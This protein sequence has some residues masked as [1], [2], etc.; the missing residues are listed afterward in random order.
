MKM[1]LEIYNQSYERLIEIIDEEAESKLKHIRQRCI[2]DFIDRLES[3]RK[4][5]DSAYNEILRE[6]R[7]AEEIAQI[8]QAQEEQARASLAHLK[9]LESSLV[10]SDPSKTATSDE[11]QA[12]S[13]PVIVDQTQTEK[14]ELVDVAS[15]IKALEKTDSEINQTISETKQSGEKD[16]IF[17]DPA[18]SNS[19]SIKQFIKSQELLEHIRQSISDIST[20][21][22][23]KSYKNE[24]TLFIRTQINS[25]SNS[26]SQHLNTK[27]RLLSSL[28]SGE[29]VSF[30][31]RLIDANQHPQARTYSMDLAAQTF[32]TVGTR[33]VNSVPAI[34]KSMAIVISGIANNN[35]PLFQQLIIGHLQERCPYLIPIHPQ[36]EDYSEGGD[37]Q[38]RFKIA[39]GYNYDTKNSALE[40]EDKYL[41][42]MRSMV[43]IYGCIL[44]QGNLGQ[45]WTWLASYVSLNPQPVIS[46]TVL[47]AFLQE[48]SKQMTSTY[49][50]QFNKLMTF[51]KEHYIKK[52]EEVTSKTSDRQSFIKLT[53][54]LSNMW[55]C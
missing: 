48:T 37:R 24:L 23:H 30:Q 55:Y 38:V 15:P 34:A 39:C 27:V 6:C 44:M 54:L 33:L 51:I 52:I 13:V 26:D 40:T 18:F 29:R 8:K 53:N 36:I 45:A 25:I 12:T 50:C 21:A 49:L 19:V 47:Q 1:D 20:N 9:N 41:A 42:R 22:N 2:K 32:V 17:D 3:S 28:F 46:A 11:Q 16:T 35:L 31:N 14:E 7:E 43:L 4:E 5:W 10:V